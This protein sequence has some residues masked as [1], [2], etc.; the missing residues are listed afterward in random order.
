M[1]REVS[2]K[3]TTDIID[4]ITGISGV[5][6]SLKKMGAGPG[7]LIDTFKK[8]CLGIT[9][10]IGTAMIGIKKAWDLAD[11]ATQYERFTGFEKQQVE[12]NAVLAK[13]DK[14][15]KELGGG[16]DSNSDKVG[17]FTVTIKDA[18]LWLRQMP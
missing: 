5:S 8:H 18:Q 4:A 15:I 2:L 9:A 16:I 1:K 13:R 11:M 7:S 6:T 12:I 17:R 10:A 3:I 14:I